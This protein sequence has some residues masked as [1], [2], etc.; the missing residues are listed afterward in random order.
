MLD[1]GTEITPCDDQEDDIPMINYQFVPLSKLM[2]YQKD[3]FI[4]SFLKSLCQI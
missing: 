4:G 3:D 2:E 1:P